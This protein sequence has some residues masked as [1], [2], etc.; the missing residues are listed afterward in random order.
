MPIVTGKKQEEAR[1]D[2][3]VSFL[4]AEEA[5]RMTSISCSNKVADWTN[6]NGN[7][8]LGSIQFFQ[9]GVLHIQEKRIIVVRIRIRKERVD[10][11]ERLRHVK[12]RGAKTWRSVYGKGVGIHVFYITTL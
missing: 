6:L 9:D 10:K 8:A 2:T 12:N 4:T 7:Q 1:C 5:G 3:V 11:G